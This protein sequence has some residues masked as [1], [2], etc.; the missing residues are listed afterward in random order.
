M[1]TQNL[2]CATD[3]VARYCFNDKLMAGRV[4]PSNFSLRKRRDAGKLSTT[5]IECPTS[6]AQDYS[7]ALIRL[8]SPTVNGSG[9]LVVFM[10]VREICKIEGDF[11]LIEVIADGHVGN[12][13][14]AAIIK[15]GTA[16]DPELSSFRVQTELAALANKSHICSPICRNR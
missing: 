5:W 15:T 14:H 3:T 2:L 6:G 16:N 7:S 12:P 8:P 11:G 10:R 13:C 1:A 4:S 9:D